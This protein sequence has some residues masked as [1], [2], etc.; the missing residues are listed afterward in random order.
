MWEPLDKMKNIMTELFTVLAISVASVTAIYAIDSDAQ[1]E[2]RATEWSQMQFH[3]ASVSLDNA[4]DRVLWECQDM[5]GMYEVLPDRI[6][7][8]IQSG[9]ADLST[10]IAAIST[11]EDTDNFDDTI[12]ETDEYQDYLAAFDQYK[13]YIAKPAK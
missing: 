6:A 7:R 13:M 11:L 12:G 1:R 2:E 9:H 5:G 3:E 8:E 4:A 10:K